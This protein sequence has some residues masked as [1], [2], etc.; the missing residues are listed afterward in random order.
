VNFI[1]KIKRH[2]VFTSLKIGGN[3]AIDRS[4]SKLSDDFFHRLTAV[5]RLVIAER[6][7]VELDNEIHHGIFSGMKLSS[8]RWG[9]HD[10][11]PMM[12][13]LYESEVTSE[14]E[15]AASH[16]TTFVDVGAADGYFAV[17]SVF[18]DLYANAICF[19]ISSEGRDSIKLNAERNGVADKVSIHAEATEEA[20]LKMAEGV[21]TKDL[22]IL[23][24]IEGGEFDLFTLRVL[25]AFK[26]STIL[27]EIHDFTEN[28][29][30][31]Y[32]SLK[33]MAESIFNIS[34]ITQESRNPNILVS[35]RVLHDDDKW[36]LMSEGRPKAM[37]WLRLT[38]KK[39]PT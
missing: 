31:R 35:T 20:L 8:L 19:E 2:G 25:Q 6:L 7:A 24:D 10:K 4:L 12:L 30:K 17:G 18:S 39:Q 11:A 5:R 38:P 27:V 33:L 14:I 1:Q 9:G 26:K 23:C 37:T 16:T 21:D 34:E 28:D 29:R 32:I 36:L 22:F 13:G 15:K 3:L